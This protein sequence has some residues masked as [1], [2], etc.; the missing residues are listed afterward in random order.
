MPELDDELMKRFR[1]G[2]GEAFNLIVRR[3]RVALVNFIA[4]FIGGNQDSAEDLAQ[5]T[6]V[7]MFKASGRYK[8]GTAK[9][10]TWMYHIASNLCK[11]E[12]RNRGRRG[13]FFVDNVG[14][15]DENL[16]H[17]G[18][19]DLIAT[20]PADSAFQPD[21]E[22]ERKELK[23]TVQNAIAELPERYR[24]PVSL[25]D[26]QGLSYEEISEVLNLPLGTTKSRINRARLML[27][28][29]LRSFVES[30]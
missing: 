18:A 20:A 4:H 11:N 9:F 5:E 7:R 23:R 10:S 24:L 19:E 13:R 25:R 12:L 2:D 3:H 22:L 30:L 16:G 8:A 28:D 26:L 29:K 21:I 14:T 6:F 17:A 15:H 1:K 27:K